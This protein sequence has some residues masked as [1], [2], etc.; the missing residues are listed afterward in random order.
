M[1]IAYPPLRVQP[2]QRRAETELQINIAERIVP[3][4]WPLDGAIAVNPLTGL[5]ELPF[6]DAVKEGAELFDANAALPLQLWRRLLAQGRLSEAA[7]RDAAVV[8]LGGADAAADPVGAGVSMLDCMMARLTRLPLNPARIAAEDPAMD[9]VAKW[10]AA[11]FDGG[12]A[13]AAMPGRDKGL[14]RA[15]LTLIGHDPVFKGL[16]EGDLR[17]L[18]ASVPRDAVDA[19]TQGLEVLGIDDDDR[20]LFLQR[21]IARLP[22][23]AGHIRWRTDHVDAELVAH[24]PADMASLLALQL[25]VVRAAPATRMRPRLAPVVTDV[26]QQLAQHFGF[27]IDAGGDALQ[28]V[29]AGGEDALGA[30]FQRAAEVG[31]REMLVPRL[32]R[33]QAPARAT[34]PDAQLVMCIDVRSEPYRRAFE[35]EGNFETFGYAGFFGLMI[36]VREPNRPRTRQLPV[37]VQP[38][39][40]LT[41]VAAPGQEKAAREAIALERRSA[42]TRDLFGA[43]K[44]GAATAFAT[45]EAVGPLAGALMVASTLLPRAAQKMARAMK[46]DGAALAPSLDP[47]P[48]GDAGLSA[49]ERLAYARALF[50][51]TGME[52]RTARLVVLAGHRGQTVNN[53]YGAAYDCGACAGHGGA[54]NARAMAAIMNDPAV[55]AAL[56]AEGEAIP[57][58]TIFVPAEH[59]TTVDEVTLFD[60]CCLPASHAEDLAKLRAA[61]ARA[62]VANRARRAKLLHRPADDLATGAAHWGEVRPEWGLAGNA[63]FI[64]AQR[65]FTADIDLEGRSFLHS[66]DWRIDPTGEALATILTAPMV[67]AQWINCQYLFSTLDNRRF[68]AGDKTIHNPVGR[69]GVLRGNGGDLAVGLPMQAL[70]HD[71]GTPAHVPQRLL[72]IVQAPY[73]LVEQVVAGQAV[74]R[75]LF[76]N[77]WVQ[78]VVVDPETG[79]AQRWRPDTEMMADGTGCSALVDF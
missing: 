70:F 35:A 49:E 50:A 75:R 30:I 3:P 7:L 47:V 31:Y 21:L 43:M 38:Q 78:L 24:A 22:G 45:A 26:A 13:S 61:L 28:Q 8:A 20:I 23:W 76:G 10:C 44:G 74:L 77:G 56:A 69:I 15:V 48:G 58:D 17:A 79:A 12:T 71:D 51:L 63:A 29:S 9:L 36:A 42:A 19:V 34:R 72:T 41:M 25:L 2:E 4:V 33:P 52:R 16:A 18:L 73:A 14:Y 5:E 60:T 66:Y 32:A 1:N 64:V 68:G 67:V 55:R 59:D 53:P 54:A 62:G 57:E 40:D 11:F 37:L 65:S 46:G 39:Q 27:S 6:E